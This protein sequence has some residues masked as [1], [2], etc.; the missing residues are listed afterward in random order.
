MIPQSCSDIHYSLIESNKNNFIFNNVCC[1][2]YLINIEE[3]YR[4]NMSEIYFYKKFIKL[5]YELDKQSFLDFQNYNKNSLVKFIFILN[6]ASCYFYT[7]KKIKFS[8]FLC[9]LSVKISQIIF[10]SDS[11]N[12]T[13]NE[14][15]NNGH[16]SEEIKDKNLISNIYNNACC[17]YLQTF[18][19]N[20]C[21]KFLEY[22]FKNIEEND[23]ND[24]LIYYNNLLIVKAKN[25]INYDNINIEIKTLEKLIKSRKEFFNNL[26]GD[27]L[28]CN[29]GENSEKIKIKLKSNEENYQSFKL[30]CFIIHN[31]ILFVEKIFKQED[32]AKNLY[33]KNY[34][35]VCSFLGKDSFEAQKFLIRL[36][37][38]IKNKNLNFKLE[39][40][41]KIN[42]EKENINLKLKISNNRN[43]RHSERDLNKR[44]N[45]I[46]EKIEEFEGILQNEKIINMLK[47]KNTNNE[48]IINELN[49]S[50]KLV[51][52]KE[53]IN[54]N[55]IN[56][57]NNKTKESE[58]KN[59]ENNISL[60]QK[61]EKEKISFDM[62]DNMIEEFKKE[63]QEKEE[64]SKKLIQ[65]KK[66]IEKQKEKEQKKNDNNNIIINQNK[67][68]NNENQAPKKAPRIK[69]LFQ[70][71]I[72][73]TH[74]EPK[75]T[76]L[77]E[78]FQSLM[79]GIKEEKKEENDMHHQIFEEKKE[80]IKVQN[81]KDNNF[82]TLDDDND[83]NNTINND[84]ENVNIN[85][86]KK[87]EKEE[88]ENEI[89]QDNNSQ[90]C[91]YGF[92]IKVNLDPTSYNYDA[93]TLYQKNES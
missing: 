68:N 88:K 75:K 3:Y 60:P 55:N 92:T 57:E 37:D 79:G 13:D 31:Y 69:K 59:N 8:K 89:N 71:V 56:I 27:N 65:E 1:F 45:N 90:S 41:N 23:I 50:I 83:I 64:L 39:E 66:E 82:I 16:T 53:E 40:E 2:D 25:I 19:Y 11:E 24:K 51:N 28:Y 86:S 77:G 33:R 14:Y 72:G 32:E 63:N 20:K 42:V 6:K 26:Y 76:K 78:L 58:I 62:L 43:P 74:K 30:L 85:N 73:T 93:T 22:S 70:K 34:E 7:H 9:N 54:I 47:D 38:E 35:Y 80:E 29:N 15:E 67:E 49:E 84:S 48:K 4:D 44:L 87:E 18:S 5:I 91:G 52:N 17:N 36:N 21:L 81:E 12:N 61:K 10:K 46:I